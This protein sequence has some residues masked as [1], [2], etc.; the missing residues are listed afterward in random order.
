MPPFMGLTSWAAFMRG[1]KGE[2]MIMGDLVLMQDEVNPVMSAAFENGLQI[3]ALHNRRFGD[4]RA[5]EKA[6]AVIVNDDRATV[7][8][9]LAAEPSLARR[10]IAKPRFYDSK[11]LHWLYVGDT[12]LHLAAAGYRVEI[13]RLLLAA[14]ADP[15]ANANHRAS[16]PLHYAADGYIK[17]P[18]WDAKRQVKM[19][20]LLIEAGA[21]IHAQDKNG[22]T[23]LHRAVRT[24]CAA[25]VQCLL[26][27]GADPSLKTNAIQR[28][29]TSRC[30]TPAMAEAARQQ[31]SLRSAESYKPCSLM[32]Q[33]PAEEQQRQERLAI[34]A[35][36]LDTRIACRSADL[37]R[38]NSHIGESNAPGV[39]L[40]PDE[41]G[42]R[43]YTRRI[44]SGDVGIFSNE[45]GRFLPIKSNDIRL[46]R[47]LDFVA[48]PLS[49]G[50]TLP[51]LKV[52][53]T[54]SRARICDFVDGTRV[55]VKSAVWL[56]EAGITADPRQSEPRTR[57]GLPQRLHCWLGPAAA[58]PG[59][60][61][62]DP[63]I[64]Q[65]SRNC[66]CPDRKAWAAENPFAK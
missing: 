64:S 42:I 6:L 46:T 4:V 49:G 60:V 19:I 66:H 22:A 44:S 35:K 2:A 51:V 15:N 57:C 56:V 28:R 31:Q 13:A 65:K 62:S 63:G 61:T 37:D 54:R 21:A 59:L 27:A 53:L 33:A 45:P 7:K 40:Q 23:A 52:L 17:G 26:E 50:Q 29:F 20:R 38:F 24:R 5:M 58:A 10:S 16:R 34:R 11:I 55:R 32:G 12:L 39:G 18:V 8:S 1:M 30:K 47:D 48:L 14:G 43:V 41:A 25:A 3:T 36:R 9:L